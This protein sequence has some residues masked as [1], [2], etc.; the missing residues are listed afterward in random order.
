MKDKVLDESFIGNN[1]KSYERGEHPNSI[2]NLKSFP[3]GISGNPK[4]RPHKYK[5]LA[6]ALTQIGNKEIIDHCGIYKGMSYKEG[7]LKKIWIK[8]Y[9]GDYKFIQMLALLRCLDN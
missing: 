4:G 9:Q 7:V 6:D 2:K 8:A 3:K 1:E 5:K